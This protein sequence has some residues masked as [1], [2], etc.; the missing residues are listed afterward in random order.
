MEMVLLDE[1]VQVWLKYGVAVSNF[2]AKATIAISKESFYFYVWK[3]LSN[4]CTKI[5]SN[6]N[7]H[8]IERN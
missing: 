1:C 3:L 6:K 4:P 5:L 7:A 8:T 2:D